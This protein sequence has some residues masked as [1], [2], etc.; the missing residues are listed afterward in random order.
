L[1]IIKNNK[2]KK[3]WFAVAAVAMAMMVTPASH[4]QV[5]NS[6]ATP[7]ALNATLAES[8]TLAVLPNTATFTLVPN[9]V[10]NIQTISVTTTWVLA[11]THTGMTVY[12]YF[13]STTA[14]ADA[15]GNIIPTSSFK[16]SV[17]LGA[18]S[19]FTGGAGPF[20]VNSKVVYAHGAFAA[21]QFNGNHA[22][23]LGLEIDTTGLAL[24]ASNSY[25]GTLNIQAQAI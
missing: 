8:L 19:A 1:R 18:Y 2:N 15:G 23:T 20:G 10:S 22:D 11:T 3:M 13:G 14:L 7:V 17:N 4:A 6:G 9:G 21:G 12:A 16:G 25:A 5:L 24:P